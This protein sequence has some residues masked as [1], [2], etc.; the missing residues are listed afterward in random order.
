MTKPEAQNANIQDKDHLWLQISTM[1]YFRGLIRSV[2]AGFYDEIELDSPT[3]DLGCGDGHFASVVF[4]RKIEIG[5]DPW[6]KPLSEAGR[7]QAYQGLTQSDGAAQPFPDG[8]FCSAVSNSVLEHIPHIDEVLVETARVLR[9]GAPLIFCVP[10]E[11]YLTELAIPSILIRFGLRY[12]ADIYT[13]WFRRMS[14]VH[15]ADG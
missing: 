13:D 3:L 15:H 6:W 9:P 12:L 8:Y 14:R 7:R 5:T 2:E 4:D 1:P 11:R 10:N